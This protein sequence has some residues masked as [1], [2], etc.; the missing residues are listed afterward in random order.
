MNKEVERSQD[1]ESEAKIDPARL[2]VQRTN[3]KRLAG[4][5]L[6]KIQEE[7]KISH[8]VFSYMYNKSHHVGDI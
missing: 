7:S 6:L 4:N 3:W 8:V 5:E 2:K 1:S